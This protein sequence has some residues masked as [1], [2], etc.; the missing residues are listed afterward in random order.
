MLNYLKAEN[1]KCKRTFLKKNIFIAPITVL[2]ITV[3]APMWFQVNA[4][5]W[6]YM[7]IFPG[8]I[9]LSCYLVHQKEEKKLK[10]RAVFSLPVDLKK[11]WIAKNLILAIYL[12]LACIVL[13]IG[14]ILGAVVFPAAKHFSF[15][16][17]IIG[18][19]IIAVTSLWQVPL[20]LFLSKKLG[21]FGVILI[22]VAGGGF[23]SAVIAVKSLWWLFPYCWTSRLMCPI[24]GILPNGT[25][26]EAGDIL[27]NPNAIPSGII[28]SVLLFLLLIFVTA[29]WFVKQEVA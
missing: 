11:V 29:H 2:L 14:I 7:L 9:A 8:F 16:Q 13:S 24:L 6:W 27:L 1:L 15:S 17:I 23:V 4:F 3:L 5:N 18:S 20:C 22:N 25:L 10:Y 28:M 21:A 26:A 12:L 19:T